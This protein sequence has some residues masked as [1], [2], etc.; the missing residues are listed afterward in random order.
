MG[1]LSNVKIIITIFLLM[2]T[3]I[4]ISLKNENSTID[5]NIDLNTAL[6]LS[7]TT[8]I[9]EESIQLPSSVEQG[10][11]LDDYIYKNYYKNN[12]KVSLYIG[13]YRNQEKVGSAHSPLVCFPGQGWLLAKNRKIRVSVNS[14]ILE[15]ESMVISKGN[16]KQLVLYWFQAYDKISSGTYNQ[17]INLLISKLKFSREDNAFVRIM[18][19]LNDK[20]TI[21]QAYLVG[22]E[23]INQFYPDFI[24]FMTIK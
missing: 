8:W 20:L 17:K 23:F 14:D 22:A 7:F 10:L 16:E 15:I 4:G 9:S 21:E 5:R 12:V 1:Q 6:D 24:K 11:G 2:L 19:P 18:V 13:Y 3:T